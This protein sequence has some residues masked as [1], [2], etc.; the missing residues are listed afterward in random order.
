MGERDKGKI[1]TIVLT[2]F[3]A[4]MYIG[5]LAGGL[6]AY[7]GK[8]QDA[9]VLITGEKDE[10]LE[11]E[12]PI[13]ARAFG[14]VLLTLAPTAL[15]VI[16]ALHTPF[17]FDPWLRLLII[18]GALALSI[19]VS[20]LYIDC[21]DQIHYQGKHNWM[22]KAVFYG[23]PYIALALMTLAC[24]LPVLLGSFEW[25][26]AL[27]RLLITILFSYPI[28]FVSVFAY[29]LFIVGIILLIYWVYTTFHAEG[30]SGGHIY[31]FY[32]ED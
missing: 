3:I 7:Y 5:I 26:P 11:G 6:L 19:W 23:A 4:L 1:A 15:M 28:Y 31:I 2:V 10:F 25:Q 24:V 13:V 14:L 29:I 20:T 9:F 21:L 22:F 17:R 8:Y 18:A 27:I 12:F 30:G 32:Y 16:A